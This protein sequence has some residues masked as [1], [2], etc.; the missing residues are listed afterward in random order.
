[1]RIAAFCLHGG[2]PPP[3][4]TTHSDAEPVKLRILLPSL[5]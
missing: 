4:T 5:P 2:M 1:M 3:K